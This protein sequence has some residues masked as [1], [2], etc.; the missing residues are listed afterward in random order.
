ML[1]IASLGVFIILMT[2]L[3]G[4]AREEEKAAKPLYEEKPLS[5]F[6][7]GAMLVGSYDIEET[8]TGEAVK[9]YDNMIQDNPQF[10]EQM[11]KI[12]ETVGLDPFKDIDKVVAAVY[13]I[14]PEDANVLIM[15]KGNF[16]Q[17]RIIAT[18]K[19]EAPNP[20]EEDSYKNITYYKTLLEKKNLYLA[21]PHSQFILGGTEL[22]LFQN[23]IDRFENPLTSVLEDNTLREVLGIVD[24]SS[25][26]WLA[27]NV[28][29][30][31]LENLG[32]D[33][34][35]QFLGNIKSFYFF[36]RQT[37]ED[38]SYTEIGTICSSAESAE[39]VKNAVQGLLNQAK[40]LIG[41]FMAGNDAFNIIFDNILI[42]ADGNR[43]ILV[44]ELTNEEIEEF[45]TKLQEMQKQFEGMMQPPQ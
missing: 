3:V 38:I 42:K 10:K 5:V 30:S 25:P 15:G 14:S 45:Q 20:V 33:P 9:E 2:L 16:D 8:R 19:E 41:M 26:F 40:G 1:V 24:K 12:K 43:A 32:E 11:D 23:S 18:L 37:G 36:S 31:V 6:P 17:E 29:P 22:Q 4:C 39:E 21:F 34:N 35:V 27:G 28:P 7:P 44:L 13:F